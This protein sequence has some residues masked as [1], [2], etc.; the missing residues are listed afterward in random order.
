MNRRD[1]AYYGY[2]AKEAGMFKR[3]LTSKPVV[4][5]ARAF[6]SRVL[7][8]AKNVPNVLRTAFPLRGPEKFITGVDELAQNDRLWGGVGKGLGSG[9]PARNVVNG[10]LRN[11]AAGGKNSMGGT[12]K[13]VWNYLSGDM[14]AY[15]K[16]GFTASPK[17]NDM[18]GQW[19]RLQKGVQDRISRTPFTIDDWQ[20]NRGLH[21]IGRFSDSERDILNRSRQRIAMIQDPKARQGALEN[22]HR[23]FYK[24]THAP[25]MADDAF[26]TVYN[27]M[28]KVP[29]KPDGTVDLATYRGREIGRRGAIGV[30]G[31]AIGGTAFNAP[32][33]AA[34]MAGQAYGGATA[35]PR[36][37]A[38]ARR[39][40]A[41]MY[42]MYAQ[43]PFMN[44][45]QYAMNPQAMLQQMGP[46]NPINDTYNA[47]YN[48][49]QPNR[50]G[51]F[52]YLN[53]LVNPLGGNA[54]GRALDNATIERLRKH[55]SYEKQGKQLAQK[56]LSWLAK[57]TPELLQAARP[58]AS[59]LW[60][61]A[62]PVA[63]NAWKT[64]ADFWSGKT[65]KGYRLPAAGALTFG[66]GML[67]MTPHWSAENA[68]QNIEDRAYAG[69]A[70]K[71]LHDSNNPTGNQFLDPMLRFGG[72]MF[73]GMM[74]NIM[75]QRDPEIGRMIA[76]RQQMI[77]RQRQV[78]DLANYR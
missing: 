5:G 65:G 25:A 15:R 17:W 9:G 54:M 34:D 13:D 57:K 11:V 70:A 51:M 30:G 2:M 55:A 28:G 1:L 14:P 21:T 60:Q 6:G 45:M 72:A 38:G 73:P 29:L 47:M 59:K 64:N 20:T 19:E 52:G 3:L 53:D 33:S 26:D 71:F 27:R 40:A 75:S 39:G 77:E 32:F 69:G 7:Q 50:P 62:K 48:N 63:S 36:A 35:A 8:S 41:D 46:E 58:A 49:W 44:R 16:P 66:T 37:E 42:S 67:A 31:L 68:R 43:L 24:D 74:G 76:E 22:L 56:G 4:E 78:A 23:S 12:T 18:P 61:G 10:E